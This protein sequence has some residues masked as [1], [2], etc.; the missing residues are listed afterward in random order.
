MESNEKFLRLIIFWTIKIIVVYQLVATNS[1][2]FLRKNSAK[3]FFKIKIDNI[4]MKNLPQVRSNPVRKINLKIVDNSVKPT[5]SAI[6]DYTLAPN[7]CSINHPYKRHFSLGP[8]FL[9]EAN[10][11]D[12]INNRRNISTHTR[13]NS[14]S[15]EPVI[16]FSSTIPTNSA[17]PESIKPHEFSKSYPTALVHRSPE[18]VHW[19]RHCITFPLRFLQL[20]TATLYILHRRGGGGGREEGGEK[21]PIAPLRFY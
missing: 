16:Y 4:E 9:K 21:F 13:E 3:R 2:I 10:T 6:R 14:N 1:F 15:T 8:F 12:S 18:A 11:P 20:S 7:N 5:A 17:L 19:K